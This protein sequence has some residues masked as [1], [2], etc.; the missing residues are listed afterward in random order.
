MGIVREPESAPH[1]LLFID[2]KMNVKDCGIRDGNTIVKIA[3]PIALE[4]GTILATL[5][6]PILAVRFGEAVERTVEEQIRGLFKFID[7]SPYDVS[8]L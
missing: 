7:A 4:D 2:G 8:N 5:F 1:R 3:E 6:K